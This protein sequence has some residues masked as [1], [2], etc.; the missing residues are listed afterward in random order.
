MALSK[1]SE[2]RTLSSEEIETR[3][4]E[5]KREL[6]NLRFQSA[7]RQTVQPHQFKHVRHTLAQLMTLQRERELAQ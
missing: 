3:I 7:T 6:F 5:L 1:M 2:L 4:D